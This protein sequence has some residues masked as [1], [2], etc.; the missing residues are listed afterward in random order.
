[1]TE[2]SDRVDAAGAPKAAFRET[3]V[4]ALR[5]TLCASDAARPF[6]EWAKVPITGL[7]R[8]AVR[9]LALNGFNPSPKDPAVAYGMTL[10]L[11]LAAQL[12][13]DP[14]AVYPDVFSQ[15]G[16]DGVSLSE[17]EQTFDTAPDEL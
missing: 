9:D 7:V 5:R 11:Q 17:I 8:R 4:A 12:M 1:M 6:A 3:G 14:S 10:G 2:V 15:G 13:E 16:T